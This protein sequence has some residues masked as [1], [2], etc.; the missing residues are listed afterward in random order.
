MKSGMR[1]CAVLCVLGLGIAS[2]T[3]GGDD[4]VRRALIHERQMYA[5]IEE[6][7]ESDHANTNLFGTFDLSSN[8]F[9]ALSGDTLVGPAGGR[10]VVRRDYSV[11][12]KTGTKSVTYRY[13]ILYLPDTEDMPLQVIRISEFVTER[14]TSKLSFEGG[15]RDTT[16][17]I[18]LLHVLTLEDILALEQADRRPKAS[19]KAELEK[20]ILN[21][22]RK[23][24]TGP[25]RRKESG[26]LPGTP[27]YILAESNRDYARYARVNDRHPFAD[28]DRA[29]R[30]ISIEATFSSLTVSHKRLYVGSESIGIHGFGLE[31]GFGDRVLN[32]VAFQSPVLTWGLRFLVFFNDARG[33]LI[34]SSFFLD[35]KILGRTPMNTAGLIDRWRLHVASPVMSLDRPKMNVTSGATFEIVTGSPYNRVPY[36]TFLYSGGAKDYSSPSIRQQRGDSSMAFY[37]TR[38]WEASLAFLWNADR[39]MYNRFRLDLG[40]GTYDVREVLYR[41]NGAFAVDLRRRSMSEVQPVIQLQY[42]HVSN[43]A[44]FGARVRFF[45]NRLTFTPWFKVFDSGPHEIRL[46]SILMPKPVGRSI[47]EWEVEHGNLIQIRYRYGFDK[48]S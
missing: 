23:G 9:G 41:A 18:E 6:K 33:S 48:N 42:T 15:E 37:S 4:D 21:L 13:R 38:Q 7:V 12:G 19:F 17:T 46:E 34:D 44:R 2:A 32:Q 47:R 5:L 14:T 43:R 31:A 11:G 26:I 40:A 27:D 36:V 39:A 8:D 1:F 10:I 25:L 22:E 30:P 20:M 16:D 24:R 28:L 35:M 29:E 45:D 3:A